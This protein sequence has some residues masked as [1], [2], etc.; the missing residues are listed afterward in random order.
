MKKEEGKEEEGKKERMK[1]ERC[2]ELRSK[3]GMKDKRKS[4][5]SNLSVA[6]LSLACKLNKVI[7]SCPDSSQN[8]FNFNLPL[9][10]L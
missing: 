8:K 1:R 9:S 10:I 2:K 3:G 6:L 7:F 4:Q 5:E